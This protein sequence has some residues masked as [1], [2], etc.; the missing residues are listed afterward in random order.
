MGR[1]LR[2]TFKLA[3]AGGVI[4]GGVA[5]ARKLMGGLGPAPG[6]ADAPGE[7][8]SLVP[9]PVTADA[10]AAN[11][12]TGT[13]PAEEAP[14]PVEP[15]VVPDEPVV[16]PPPPYPGSA[17]LITEVPAAGADEGTGPTT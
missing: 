1:L 10:A 13:P 5:V 11:G 4:A 14:A 17:A 15:V 6:S 7:W 16:E 3:V 9:D 12:A 8:P 2:G